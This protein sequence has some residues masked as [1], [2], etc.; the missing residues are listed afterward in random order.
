MPALKIE[1][2]YKIKGEVLRSLVLECGKESLRESRCTWGPAEFL[3]ARTG[4]SW[5]PS[6]SELTSSGRKDIFV[7]TSGCAGICNREPLI[8]VE[9]VGEEPVKYADVTRRRPGEI[10][11]KHVLKGEVIPDW[12]F[13]RG[14]EQKEM[15]FEGPSS[16][17]TEKTPH[18]TGDSILRHAEPGG[19]EKPGS[20]PGREDRGVHRPGR[21]FCRGKGALS[22][23]PRRDHQGGE[24]LRHSRPRRRRISH[25]HEVGVRRQVPGET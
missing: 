12:V 8:T 19:H 6:R 1:D 17:K 2:L 18:T 3:P 23:G 10:F 21:L 4:T 11:Q 25:G 13:A 5:R 7:T 22:D 24:D 16:P 20:D 9:R 15:D 14:W